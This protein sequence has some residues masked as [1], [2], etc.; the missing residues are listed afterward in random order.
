[1]DDEDNHPLIEKRILAVK[2]HEVW[3]GKNHIYCNGRLI[4]GPER[5]I[6]W[7]SVLLIDAPL[8]IFAYFVCFKIWDVSPLFMFGIVILLLVIH[9]SQFQC[10]LCDPGIIPRVLNPI[11]IPDNNTRDIVID[12]DMV[13]QSYCRTC[14]IWRPPRAHHC[15]VCDNCIT[16][17]DHHCPWMGNCIGARNY[18]MFVIFLW[19]TS[20]GCFYVIGVSIFQILHNMEGHF[21]IGQ[22]FTQ[23]PF[24]VSL[25]V[26]SV[27]IILSVGGLA[28]YHCFLIGSGKS[29]YEAI[30]LIE[31]EN[32]GCCKNYIRACCDP[33][34]PS[35]INLR[36]PV[37]Y[38]SIKQTKSV[39]LETA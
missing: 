1:M 16:E 31:T 22:A 30:K 34:K 27:I 5:L 29:T 28:I 9:L 19:S 6:F 2:Q 15:S 12:G 21:E 35:L 26:Y 32:P 33:V 8:F 17:F 38:D 10:S 37:T 14:Y 7:V 39:D 36:G 3:P 20:F 25:I 24:S 4:T 11:E 23:D 13:R 18:R